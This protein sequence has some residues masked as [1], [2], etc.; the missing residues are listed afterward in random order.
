MLARSVARVTPDS[1]SMACDGSAF[2]AATCPRVSSR[3]HVSSGQ[4]ATP[5]CVTDC[6]DAGDVS[7]WLAVT[8]LESNAAAPLAV[9]PSEPGGCGDEL[10][11]PVGRCSPFGA[12]RPPAPR[13][14]AAEGGR[15]RSRSAGVSGHPTASAS[16]DG[17][18][19]AAMTGSWSAVRCINA[20]P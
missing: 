1:G 7:G 6:E 17:E 10:A 16:P 12:D 18:A 5:S 2:R 13:L 4:A 11:V 8:A 14:R 15:G 3:A 9:L 19:G 20:D